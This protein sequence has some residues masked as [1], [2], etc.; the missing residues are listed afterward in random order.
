MLFNSSEVLMHPDSITQTSLS[1]SSQLRKIGLSILTVWEG[2]KTVKTVPA[3]LGG[4]HT[5]LKQGVNKRKLGFSTK[6]DAF[7]LGAVFVFSRGVS[8]D[9]FVPPPQRLEAPVRKTGPITPRTRSSVTDWK[10]GGAA[11][12]KTLSLPTSF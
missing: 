4:S 1:Q 10:V 9:R 11:G 12:W 6:L 3:S 5:L 8:G 7:A 2:L